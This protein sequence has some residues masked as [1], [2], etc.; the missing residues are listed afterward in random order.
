[1]TTAHPPDHRP[2]KEPSRGVRP[3]APQTVIRRICP[4]CLAGAAWASECPVCHSALRDLVRPVR[5][6]DFNLLDDEARLELR[7]RKIGAPK[8]HPDVLMS[9][10]A[11]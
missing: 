3:L 4:A 5:V 8:S 11:L 7:T 9:E 6:G 1:M 2:R 10:E